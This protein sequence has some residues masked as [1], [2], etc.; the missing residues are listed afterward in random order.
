MK[1]PFDSDEAKNINKN[2]FE[3]I[4]YGS[5]KRTTELSIKRND[6]M[7]K[8]VNLLKKCVMEDSNVIN[9]LYNIVSNEF[10]SSNYLSYNYQID[11]LYHQLKPTSRELFDIEGTKELLSYYEKI[12][13]RP[14]DSD[15]VIEPTTIYDLIN[16]HT[17]NHNYI[18]SYSSFRGSPLNNGKFQ[19]DLWN[20]TLSQRYDW[21]SLREN[22]SKYG[23]RNSLCIAPCQPLLLLRF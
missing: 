2:I 18:G 13:N 6:S 23:A 16:I 22:I 21:E 19:F 8:L 4:Y 17:R 1:L 7:V 3:T 14:F 11:I 12:K 10:Y 5:M 9:F 15:I 20:V